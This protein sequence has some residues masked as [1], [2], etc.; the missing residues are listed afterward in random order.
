MFVALYKNTMWTWY[1]FPS[2]GAFKA[3][4]KCR[5]ADVGNEKLMRHK[6]LLSDTGIVE[7]PFIYKYT[8][9]SQLHLDQVIERY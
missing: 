7:C 9:T 5:A 8:D 3:A 6:R 2:G 1:D 4:A